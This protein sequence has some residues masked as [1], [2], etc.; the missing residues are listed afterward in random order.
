[1]QFYPI[2]RLI[3]GLCSILLYSIQPWFTGFS[4]TRGQQ[5]CR[6]TST[7]AFVPLRL[8]NSP[9]QSRAEQI[10]QDC[11]NDNKGRGKGNHFCTYLQLTSNTLIFLCPHCS[12][13]YTRTFRC[14]WG[15]VVGGTQ[16]AHRP[17]QSRPAGLHHPCQSR[18]GTMS[19][20]IAEAMNPW[21]TNT[22]T[23]ESQWMWVTSSDT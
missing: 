12:W 6:N 10:I 5:T 19:A 7:G 11:V 9:Q 3:N 18:A 16:G 15:E 23:S 2:V 4:V 21:I 13:L 14:H 17:L 22:E 8:P 20:C 1:M